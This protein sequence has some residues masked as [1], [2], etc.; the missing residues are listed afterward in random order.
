VY[1]EPTYLVLDEPN[2]SMDD[3]GEVALMKL[4]KNLKLKKTTVIFTT[5]RPKLLAVA[6]MMLVLKNG[7]QMLF[8][9]TQ[10]VLNKLNEKR[11]SLVKQQKQAALIPSK[12]EA[13]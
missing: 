8:G 4:I 11:E 9:P 12:E 1:G 3:A 13:A 10:E 6:D 7:Q 5:H 2:A